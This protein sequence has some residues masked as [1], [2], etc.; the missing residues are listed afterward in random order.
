MITFSLDVGA[1]PWE[2]KTEGSGETD[3][4]QLLT[5]GGCLRSVFGPTRLAMPPLYS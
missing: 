2:F 3:D 5:G 1:P 4:S